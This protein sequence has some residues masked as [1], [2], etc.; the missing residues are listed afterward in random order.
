MSY[1]TSMTI[2]IRSEKN[3]DR[4]AVWRINSAAFETDAEAILV[5]ALRDGGFAEVSLVAELDGALIGHILFS[6]LVIVTETGREQA[7]SLAPM[8]VLPRYQR[9]GV[10]SS[11]VNAG[12]EACSRR[13]HKAVLVL[14]HPEYYPRFGFSAQQAEPL[15]SPFGGGS[16]WM[17]IE[18]VPGALAG[19]RGWVEYPP[20]FGASEPG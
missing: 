15:E 14:G 7:L 10:G 13:G 20:P 4:D 1:L 16:A 12:L 18:L 9:Q 5:D 3:N 17:A 11:L 2:E 6:R 8:A 19:I